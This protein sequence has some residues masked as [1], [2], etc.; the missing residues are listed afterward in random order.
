MTADEVRGARREIELRRGQRLFALLDYT[1]EGLSGGGHQL[2]VKMT[3]ATLISPC[4]AGFGRIY[5]V[6][7]FAPR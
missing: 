1:E 5:G 4:E 2:G 6:A 3:C 7:R